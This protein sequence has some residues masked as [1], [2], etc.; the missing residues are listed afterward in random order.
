[1]IQKTV[2]EED[3]LI[4]NHYLNVAEMLGTM[5]S[6][7]LEVIVHDLKNP[8]HSII[9]IF[10]GHITG[11]K[12]G[13][14]TTDLGYKR[15]SSDVP[16]KIFNYRNNSSNGI[17]LKSSS[18]AFRNSKGELLGSLCLNLNLSGFENIGILMNQIISTTNTAYLKNNEIFQPNPVEIEI[19]V[20][21]NQYIN[22]T[23]LNPL[24]LKKAEKINIL[25]YLYAEG[26][27]NKKASI[28]IVST[29]L[30]LSKPTIY[31]YLKEA[32]KNT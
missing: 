29:K 10:N 7:F 17:P 11:R 18:L 27:F 12:I 4:F 19:E 20:A 23:A 5:F 15:I 28:S 16:D 24:S 3:R 1:M 8:D 6:P 30:N 13:E 31:K 21:I 32:K 25:K 2:T 22:D 26:H 14:S 9:S